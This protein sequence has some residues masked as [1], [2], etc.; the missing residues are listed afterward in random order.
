MSTLQKQNFK[1]A[2]CDRND[3]GPDECTF[4]LSTC[5]PVCACKLSYKLQLW[6]EQFDLEFGCSNMLPYFFYA[7]HF[8]SALERL[9]RV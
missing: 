8:E 3:F 6:P 2:W 9:R 5:S 7:A 4:I 1:S